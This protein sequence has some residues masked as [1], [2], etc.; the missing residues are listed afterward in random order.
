MLP[1]ATKSWGQGGGAAELELKEWGNS[2]PNYFFSCLSSNAE[3][4]PA[5]TL[6]V[7]SQQGSLGYNSLRSSRGGEVEG[8]MK[9]EQGTQWIWG[10]GRY[11]K[12]MPS[13]VS[14]KFIVLLDTSLPYP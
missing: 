6:A 12:G 7:V 9:A 11:R 3:L 8:K 1:E 4:L 14:F 2:T 10:R 13:P 5:P